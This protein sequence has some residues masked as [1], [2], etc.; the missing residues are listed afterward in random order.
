MSRPASAATNN[1]SKWY[2][3]G[4][5]GLTIAAPAHERIEGLVAFVRVLD[6]RVLSP[7]G[8]KTKTAELARPLEVKSPSMTANPL[9]PRC[10]MRV[11]TPLTQKALA[12]CELSQSRKGGWR[13]F[14]NETRLTPS[15]HSQINLREEM[16]QHVRDTT[17]RTRTPHQSHNCLRSTPSPPRLAYRVQ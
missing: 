8:Q 16:H 7:N 13:L 3:G 14:Y 2:R 5:K 1:K 11:V 6:L 17:A 10:A 15:K 4:G 12:Q 9:C